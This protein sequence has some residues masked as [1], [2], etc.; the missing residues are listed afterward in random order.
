M[1][2]AFSHAVA[3]AAIGSAFAP[4]RSARFWIYGVICAVIPD[5]DVTGFALEVNYEDV[6]GHRGLTHS[7]LFAAVL[8]AVG[9]SMIRRTEQAR[10]WRVLTCV[11]PLETFAWSASSK[12]GRKWVGF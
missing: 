5:V 11:S 9:A 6:I 3:A 10:S 1:A 8:G 4:P 2:S 7:I 12:E